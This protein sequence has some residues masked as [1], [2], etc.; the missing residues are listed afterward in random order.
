MEERK[1]K[2]MRYSILGNTGLKV[3]Q[4]TIGTWAIG[5]DGWGDTNKRDSIGA[6][7]TMIDNGVNVIDSAP[8]YGFGESEKII[9]EAIKDIRKDVHLLTKCAVGLLPGKI[10]EKRAN[11]DAII[12]DCEDSMKRLQTDYIDLFLIHWPDDKTPLEE[13]M[14]AL[15]KL[16]QDGK[17][18]YFGAS[19]FNKEQIIESRKYGD[20]DIIQQPY[21]M[22]AQEFRSL[23]SWAHEENLGTMSYG[24]LGAGILTGGI[25]EL[26]NFAADDMRLN[27]YD[28]FKEP[29]FSK[30]ME[31]VKRLDIYAEKYN[32]PVSQVTINWSTQS[33]FLDTILMGVR[34]AAEAEEN[35][36]AFSWELE[37]SD[38]DSITNDID[39]ILGVE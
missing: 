13:T 34:N 5:G 17:I 25:R 1:Y 38:V 18:G 12:Q 7:R 4:A 23:L 22:V 36:A 39:T 2:N 31:L 9:G 11:F 32:V 16:K 3:S 19:N 10:P 20:F 6:I 33:G 21:S 8:F 27:F 29:K 30:V 26:P 24:S 35:C 14:G 37:Q 15:M 28:Y